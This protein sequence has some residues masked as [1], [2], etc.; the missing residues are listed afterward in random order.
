MRCKEALSIL[1]NND[2]NDHYY[3][4][5]R[6]T[7]TK[8]KIFNQL[9]LVDIYQYYRV[10]YWDEWDADEINYCYLTDC[11]QIYNLFEENNKDWNNFLFDQLLR[12]HKIKKGNY[13][14]KNELIIETNKNIFGHN[15]HFTIY[16]RFLRDLMILLKDGAI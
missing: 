11:G 6:R 7:N 8:S 12:F 15:R 9:I 4:L 2:E 14:F 13:K 3:F 5:A 1:S 10:S 16:K